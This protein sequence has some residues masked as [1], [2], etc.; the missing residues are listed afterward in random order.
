MQKQHTPRPTLPVPARLVTP[1]EHRCPNCA[2]R[3]SAS[4]RPALSTKKIFVIRQ[5]SRLAATNAAGN[6]IRR[7]LIFDDHPDSLRLVFGCRTDPR[8]DLLVLQRAR[9]WE[10]IL[11]LTL[12]MVVLIAMVWPLF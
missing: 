7:I 9:S 1:I 10:L 12:I 6:K 5:T 8:S 11:V 3:P 4:G 2:R